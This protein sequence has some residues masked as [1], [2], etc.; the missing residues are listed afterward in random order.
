MSR[1]NVVI[2]ALVVL[3]FATGSLAHARADSTSQAQCKDVPSIIGPAVAATINEQRSAGL[4]DGTA[5]AVGGPVVL[6]C[7][8]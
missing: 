1:Q 6:V 4:T 3:A 7:S 5:I 2:A 8:W